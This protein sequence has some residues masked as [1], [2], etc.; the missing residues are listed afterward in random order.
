MIENKI[1]A[2]EIDLTPS[3]NLEES[4]FI[5]IIEMFKEI[6]N[7]QGLDSESFFKNYIEKVVVNVEE[8]RSRFDKKY[9]FK[10]IWKGINGEN[11]LMSRSF[12][13]KYER[14]PAL[15]KKVIAM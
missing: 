11:E 3:S 8:V 7:L 15:K 10:F 1:N 2:L 5:N 9:G 6:S 4:D 13:V 12:Y 14:D